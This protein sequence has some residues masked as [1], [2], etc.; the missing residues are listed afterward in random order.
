MK[1]KYKEIFDGISP[2]EELIN[3]ITLF[4]HKKISYR[5]IAAVGCMFVLLL[6][7]GTSVYFY[8]KDAIDET[9]VVNLIVAYETRKNEGINYHIS[10]ELRNSGEKVKIDADVVVEGNINEMCIYEAKETVF[11]ADEIWEII[12]GEDSLYKG[13]LESAS[14]SFPNGSGI[15]FGVSL[16][17]CEEET[18]L[19]SKGK[20]YAEGCEISYDEAKEIADEFLNRKNIDD[21]QFVKGEIADR[22]FYGNGYSKTGFYVF[23]YSQYANGFP[24]ET[25]SSN[26]YSGVA[27][28]LSIYIDDNGIFYLRMCGLDLLEKK[29]LNSEIM[30]A[31]SAVEKVEEALPD[32]WLSEYATVVE[33]RLEY[34]L[35]QLDDG[36]LELVPC[37]HFCIDETE[38]KKMNIDIQR[39]ND[40]NDLCINA[41]TGEM[42]RVE[43]RYPVYQMSDGSF[44]GTWQR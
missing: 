35:D 21:F 32:L 30:T 29:E 5:P 42:F 9:D 37:W 44:V 17:D 39:E 18:K 43:N 10:K 28:E 31:E 7:I 15:N 4:D 19:V 26:V 41:V 34:I 38:L 8:S 24:L 27:S 14:V 6:A 11:S 36:S 40:T 3:S 23:S 33:I 25:V 22:R 20:G 13:D 12:C 2:S 1:N 16:A